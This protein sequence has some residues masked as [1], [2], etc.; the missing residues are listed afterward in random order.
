MQENLSLEYHFALDGGTRI[1]TLLQVS[2]VEVQLDGQAAM[3]M[4]LGVREG[5]V[6]RA[7]VMAWQPADAAQRRWALLA[8]LHAVFATDAAVVALELD[9]SDYAEAL[10]ALLRQGLA[11]A[12]ANG[13]VQMPRTSLLQQPELWLHGS[14]SAAYPLDYV[15]SQG[16]RHP[17]RPPQTAG[18]VYQRFIPWLNQWLSLRTLDAQA[19]LEPFHRWMNHPRVAHFWEEQG[20]LDK[21]RAFIANALA[22]PHVHPLV[23]CLDG[24]PF[25]YY[26]AYWA[27]E[28]RIAPF[29][30]VGDHDRGIHML[31]GEDWARGPQYVAAWLPSLTHYLMLDDPR[32]QAVVCEPRADNVRMVGYLQQYG[33]AYLRQFDFPHKRAAL[34][35]LERE[36]HAQGQWLAG[37]HGQTVLA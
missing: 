35:V 15:M 27:K 37:P 24:R 25:A 11:V 16:K 2:T 22:D 19:D 30:P 29:Y 14:S 32:T 36:V 31:V 7:A 5:A 4:A 21:H 13:T 3:A 12:A 1:R 17:R 28:D 34:L 26:E 18:T 6:R 10:P 20:D 33:F 9:F 8:A 23:A